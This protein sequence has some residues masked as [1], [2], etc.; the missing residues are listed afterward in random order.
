[1]TQYLV[2]VTR[3]NRM[4]C[5]E[6]EAFFGPYRDREVAGRVAG[7]VAQYLTAAVARTDEADPDHAEILG[8]SC[9]V[10]AS[11]RMMF[12]VQD[13]HRVASRLGIEPTEETE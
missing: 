8:P 3:A 2:F 11:V 1:M 7:R 10:Y 5:E 6:V 9:L 13:L 4:T 12:N